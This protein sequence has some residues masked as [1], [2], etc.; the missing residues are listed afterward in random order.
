VSNGYN[1]E[2]GAQV[3][4]ISD[5]T[6]FRRV[7]FY[8]CCGEI[9]LQ[10]QKHFVFKARDDIFPAKSKHRSC[11]PNRE[12]STKSK[13]PFSIDKYEK[14]YCWMVDTSSLVKVI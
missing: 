11:D 8:K 6:I 9:M 14:T 13:H 5:L 10:A 3:I 7:P 2:E 4:P 12:F 1:N